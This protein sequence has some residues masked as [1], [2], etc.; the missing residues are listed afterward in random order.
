[1]GCFVAGNL[2]VGRTDSG[3]RSMVMTEMLLQ[4][5]MPWSW[6]WCLCF[7]FTERRSGEEE[8]GWNDH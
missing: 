4:V 5:L 3:E 2:K 6:W 1:M 7:C 8:E